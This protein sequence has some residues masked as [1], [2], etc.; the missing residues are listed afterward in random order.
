M[1]KELRSIRETWR[2]HLRP[3]AIAV[4]ARAR[5]LVMLVEGAPVADG[6]GQ[7]GQRRTPRRCSRGPSGR[8]SRSIA[9]HPLAPDGTGGRSLA[10]WL[11]KSDAGGVTVLLHVNAVLDESR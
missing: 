10:N 1:I 6:G 2:Q 7:G 8:V 5:V 9:G 4:P 3:E 11:D